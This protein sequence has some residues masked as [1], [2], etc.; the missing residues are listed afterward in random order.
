MKRV[1]PYSLKLVD[2]EYTNLKYVLNRNSFALNGIAE[3]YL[4]HFAY[5]YSFSHYYNLFAAKSII[6]SEAI[7][8]ALEKGTSSM[9][10]RNFVADGSK[11]YVF[12]QH[13]VMYMVAL[14]SEQRTFSIRPKGRA[15][16]AL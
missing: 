4:K 1:R 14:S 11:N 10:F 5:Q 16:V 9:L 6:S 12:L 13:G 2:M 15:D 8:H 3:R 7:G